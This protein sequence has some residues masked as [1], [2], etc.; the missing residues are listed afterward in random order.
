MCK[1]PGLFQDFSKNKKK[2]NKQIPGLS[3]IFQDTFQIPGLS[4][5][6]GNPVIF[7]NIYNLMRL[8]L[9]CINLI[10]LNWMIGLIILLIKGWRIHYIKLEY[11]NTQQKCLVLTFSIWLF[12]NVSFVHWTSISNIDLFSVITIIFLLDFHPYNNPG[13]CN[14]NY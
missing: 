4:R 9:I 10:V 5:T 12:Y 3:R 14:C 8:T 11:T 1:I 7:A 6:C 13:H 2:P